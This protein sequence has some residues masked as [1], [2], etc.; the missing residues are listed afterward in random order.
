VHGFYMSYQYLD[1]NIDTFDG[2]DFYPECE[3]SG[4]QT[5]RNYL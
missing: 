3:N 2:L 4:K 1:G 5:T